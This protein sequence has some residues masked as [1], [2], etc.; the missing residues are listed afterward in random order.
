MMDSGQ[1]MRI[2]RTSFR[3]AFKEGGRNRWGVKP[4]DVHNLLQVIRTENGKIAKV[5]DRMQEWIN[6][7]PVGMES[8]IS[9]RPSIQSQTR[10]AIIFNYQDKFPITFKTDGGKTMINATQMA[11]SFGKLPAEWLRLAAT[12]EFREALVRRGDSISLGSQIMTTRGN[13]GATWIEESL[14]M[15]FA[16]WLSPD[17]SAWCNSRI[18]ELV[19]KGYASMPVHR[20]RCSS[21]SEA[22]SNFPVP[23]NFEE[24]FWLRTKRKRFVKTNLKLLFIRS[25]W[26]IEIVL[27]AGELPRSYKLQLSSCIVFW[28]KIIS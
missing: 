28:Q 13:T 10:E 15:E 21:F 16:R 17:F 22:V 14:A 6:G 12:Q 2:C 11:R 24:A 20:N 25:T 7:L 3:I 26:K 27:R 4:Y 23:Q 8:N 5:C 18:E 9:V 19:T 1:A